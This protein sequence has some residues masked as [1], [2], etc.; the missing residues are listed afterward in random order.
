MAKKQQKQQQ[1]DTEQQQDENANVIVSVLKFIPRGGFALNPRAQE[2]NEE[3]LEEYKKEMVDNTMEDDDDIDE[4]DGLTVS[5]NVEKN[6]MRMSQ[7]EAY[8][9]HNNPKDDQYITGNLSDE[10]DEEAYE[11]HEK[12]VLLISAHNSQE[13]TT[14]HVDVLEQG[15]LNK[16]LHQDLLLN[17]FCL[18][19]EW[20]DFHPGD[21]EN[22]H[23]C[24]AVATF[25]PSIEIYDLDTYNIV[26]PLA[27]LGETQQDQLND[28]LARN[29]NKNKKGKLSE[30]T[31][32]GPVQ[33]LSWNKNHRNLLSSG[34]DDCTIKIWDLN[35]GNCAQTL[36][37]H[38]DKVNQ[39]EWNPNNAEQLLSTGYDNQIILS[40]P[41]AAKPGWVFKA[42]VNPE[43]I[44]W[45]P[46]VAHEFLVSLDNGHFLVFDSRKNDPTF[47]FQAHTAPCTSVCYHP[48]IPTMVCSTS[49]DGSFKIWNISKFP[50]ISEGLVYQE[51]QEKPLFVAQF[52]EHLLALGGENKVDTKDLSTI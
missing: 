33:S 29:K 44:A 13:V 35:T 9:V 49:I 3:D 32:Y 37:H 6:L 1:Q 34:S 27:V 47:G 14:M 52:F 36:F 39:V 11:L 38:K 24:V 10:S 46:K 18:D 51:R 8:V 5:M 12:D 43:S 16:F 21:S 31:H 17:E 50:N 42:N 25:S 2:V 48:D 4:G 30:H 45:N 28:Q 20:L 7:A 26:N 40:D 41:R 22:L 23:N 19:V 15:G